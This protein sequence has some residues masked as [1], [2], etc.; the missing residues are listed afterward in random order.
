[1]DWHA[2]ALTCGQQGLP[3]WVMRSSLITSCR[4]GRASTWFID[5]ALAVKRVGMH[6]KDMEET[7]R[8]G[9]GWCKRMQG[10]AHAWFVN[11]TA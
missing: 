10:E 4:V 3:G 9:G 8:Q 6:H 5:S 1:M 2:V 7:G 11:Q